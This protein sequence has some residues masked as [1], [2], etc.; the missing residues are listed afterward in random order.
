MNEDSYETGAQFYDIFYE[1][2][3]VDIPFYTQTAK[4]AEGKVLEVACGTGRVHLELLKAG[5]DVQGF[6]LSEPMLKILKSK[7]AALYLQPRVQIA[8]MRDFKI[9]QKF[10][11]IIIPFRAFLH[12]LTTD[13]QL[14]T[15]KCCR[16]HLAANCKLMLNFF[17][18]SPPIMVNNYGRDTQTRQNISGEPMNYIT[19][20]HFVNEPEQVIEVTEYLKRGDTIVWSGT[21]KLALIYKKEFELLLRL[22]GFKKWQVYGG[23]EYEPLNSSKQEMVWVIEK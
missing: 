16:R 23:F 1:K 10:A 11:L 15:L 17:F 5:V 9:N 22:A 6:D 18:P 19:N 2:Y 14:R 3:R 13:D 12:N 7:A 20:S 4:Q 8:D 21:I